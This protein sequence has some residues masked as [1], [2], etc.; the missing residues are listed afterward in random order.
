MKTSRLFFLFCLSL[1]LSCSGNNNDII[2]TGTLTG[3]EEGTVI[4]LLISEENFMRTIQKD[5]LT[6]GTFQFTFT[7]STDVAKSY[8]IMGNG[9]GFPPA[10]LD[11]WARPGARV[12]IKGDDKLVRTWDVQSNVSEQKEANKYRAKNRDFEKQTQVVSLDT[13]ALRGEIE[14]YPEKRAE[15]R[16]RINTLYAEDDSLGLLIAENDLDI[17]E[18]NP[19]YSVFWMKKLFQ[20]SNIARYTPDYPMKDRLV[21]LYDGLS[22]TVKNTQEG[23]DIYFN[24]F[25]PTIVKVGEAMADADM[26]DVDGNLRHLA[27]YEGKFILLDFWSRSC[28]P[29]IAAIPEMKEIGEKYKDR[30]A[31]V[32]ISSDSKDLWIETSQR[33]GITWANFNEFKGRNGLFAR[34]GV[35]GIPNYFLIGPDGVINASWMGYGKGSLLAKMAELISAH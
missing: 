5:T 33:E 14:K 27:D 12:K 25:P 11:L 29:C 8:M 32:S 21:A 34:Y 18:A 3:V 13:K 35:V 4:E 26:Y 1:L 16:A 15:L 7:D 31:I 24:L 28:G 23:Q 17:M 22:E 6:N 9:E 30:L 19:T 20:Y 2:I 10:W